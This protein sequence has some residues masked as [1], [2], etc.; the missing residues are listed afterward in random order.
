LFEFSSFNSLFFSCLVVKVV[1]VTAPWTTAA[2]TNMAAAT[3]KIR[4]RSGTA[5]ILAFNEPT[6]AKLVSL[7]PNQ[8]SVFEFASFHTPFSG[9]HLVPCDYAKER[10]TRT[11]CRLF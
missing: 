3:V 1:A 5:E 6:I 11:K 4:G 10:R 2:K 7:E 8:V 9:L